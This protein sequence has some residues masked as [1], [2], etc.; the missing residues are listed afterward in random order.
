LHAIRDYFANG[1]IP[2][3]GLVCQPEQRLADFSPTDKSLDKR[4]T[5]KENRMTMFNAAK[6]L[7]RMIGIN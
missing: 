6:K 7:G 4:D 2:E 5:M 3:A 1:T